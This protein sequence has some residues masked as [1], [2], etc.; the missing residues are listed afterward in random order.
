MRQSLCQYCVSPAG[1]VSYR[2]CGKETKHPHAAL[3]V[4]SYSADWAQRKPME[5][6]VISARVPVRQ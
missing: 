3:V 1:T 4:D 6:V 2:Q 5:N